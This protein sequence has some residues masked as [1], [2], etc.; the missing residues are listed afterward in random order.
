MRL[1][2]VLNERSLDTPANNIPTAQ[3]WMQQLIDI[4]TP[5]PMRY[6]LKSESPAQRD[7]WEYVSC[8][9]R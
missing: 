9:T 4:A 2:M 1:E 8:L 6:K 5:T 7:F 3:Q